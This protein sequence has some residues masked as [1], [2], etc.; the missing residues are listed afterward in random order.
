MTFLTFGT[1]RNWNELDGSSELPIIILIPQPG[2]F[3]PRDALER[4]PAL[5]RGL[6]YIY[7]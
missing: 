1:E 2:F 4:I 6:G 5:G 7:C 3:V